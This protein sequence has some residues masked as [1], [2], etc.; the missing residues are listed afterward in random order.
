[1]SFN[2]SN[3]QSEFKRL[4]ALIA[5]MRARATRALSLV[6]ISASSSGIIGAAGSIS[7]SAPAFTP[8]AGGSGKVL[9]LAGASGLTNGAGT[10]GLVA[11]SR[12]LVQLPPVANVG[13]VAAAANEIAATLG[14]V[15]TGRPPGTPVTY[16]VSIT[17]AAGLVSSGVAG[18]L[19]II[20]A[21]LP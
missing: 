13:P 12:G 15:D 4:E 19:W 16:T 20:L 3:P 9:V 7:F 1:V 18:G 6:N 21:D 14:W 2:S 17:M 11:I 10:S 5:K 8:R